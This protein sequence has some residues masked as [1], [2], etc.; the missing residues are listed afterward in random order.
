MDVR[1]IKGIGEA[2]ALILNQT[3]LL[4]DISSFYPYKYSN[5]TIFK[6]IQG[7]TATTDVCIVATVASTVKTIY[8]KRNLI[9]SSCRIIDNTGVLNCIFYNNRYIKSSLKQGELYTF[10]GQVS[11]DTIVNPKFSIGISQP[12][13]IPIY[14][15]IK[16][17]TNNDIRR[18][19]NVSLDTNSLDEFLPEHILK[20]NNLL[21]IK[22]AIHKIHNPKNMNDVTQ[23]LYRLEFEKY[24]I[25]SLAIDNLKN[26]R[27]TK[28]IINNFNYTELSLPFN[29]TNSQKDSINDCILDLKTNK[30]LNRLI[31]GDVGCGKTIVAIILTYIFMQNN[32]QTAI[33]V[34]TE[35]LARQHMESF[36]KLL[37]DDIILLVSSL[38]ASEKK[39]ALEKIKNGNAKVIIGTTAIISD[40]VVYN[41]LGLII[42]DEQHKFGVHQRAKL[43]E[44]GNNP[45]ILVM[46]ATPIPRTLS[47]AIYGDLDISIINELPP[48]R[49]PIKTYLVDE[50]KRLRI[51]NF[52]SKICSEGRQGYIVCPLIESEDYNDDG[53]KEVVTYTNNLKKQLPNLNI[54]FIHGNMADTHKNLIM[55]DF[56]NKKIDIL[57]STTVIEVGIN[58]PNANLMIIEN[59]ERFGLST[60]HQL[61]GRVGRSSYES[62]CILF[63]NKNSERLKILKNTT[64]GFELSRQDLKLRG[65]GDFFGTRQH[66]ITDIL[67]IDIF[68]AANNAA[69]N[70]EN[71]HD[72][73]LLKS[74]IFKLLND[75]E[76]FN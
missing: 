31:Q 56:L 4:D 19:I 68:Y 33:L 7:A 1:N 24:F 3:G 70:I 15:N 5:R 38:K 61:R 60:L 53:R 58:N 30:P 73:P 16:G 35:I 47:L 55:N 27:N 9:I 51:Q 26:R 65:A 67:D 62:Y 75:K 36:K 2:K 50:S 42:F 71:L 22:D 52:I 37:G 12:E 23:S 20:E 46:S 74:K 69:K 11:G 28:C 6:T 29:L 17:I 18:I 14:K 13:I 41:N 25:F 32:F 54:D 44:K 45:H 76:I 39:E 48:N 64:D 34:P 72:Y 63:S 66:G 10:F 59:A 49:I 40:N 57:V 21:N 43:I 8:P